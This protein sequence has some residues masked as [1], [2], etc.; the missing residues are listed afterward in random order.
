MRSPPRVGHFVD[1]CVSKGAAA[2]ILCS[3]VGVRTGRE[4][5][6]RP[7]PR[8][9][10]RTV[11]AQVEEGKWAPLQLRD[12]SGSRSSVRWRRILDG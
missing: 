2:G 4:F 5:G 8:T 10:A 7:Q 9:G 1:V 12:S 11:N 6:E 3:C